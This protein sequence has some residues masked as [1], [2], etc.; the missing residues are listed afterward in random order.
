MKIQDVENIINYEFKNKILLKSAITHKSYSHEMKIQDVNSYNERLE[1]LGDAVLEQVIS[2]YLYNIEPALKEGVMSKKRAEIVC[3]DSLYKAIC[4][5]GLDSSLLV[6]KCEKGAKL[7]NKALLADMAEAIIGAIYLDGGAEAAK[8]FCLRLLDNQL[9]KAMLTDT[10]DT[11]FKTKLQE[12]LQVNGNV[13]IKYI[14]DKEEG[15]DHNK[16]FYSSVYYN[17]KKIG[18]GS[19]KTK[20]QSEQLA[21]KQGIEYIGNTH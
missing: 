2:V 11:D 7:R 1:F 9:E 17:Q 14:L 5:M 13:D 3:E 19:G 4:K 18:E 6:G 16:T 12:L 10:F 21:A 20:K 8:E 15:M